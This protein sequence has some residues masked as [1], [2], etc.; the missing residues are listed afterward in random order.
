[1]KLILQNVGMNRD[2]H[3]I[4]PDEKIVIVFGRLSGDQKNVTT[5]EN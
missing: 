4:S 2:K 3:E 5:M 1:M